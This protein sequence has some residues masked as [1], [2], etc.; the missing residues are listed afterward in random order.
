MWNFKIGRTFGLMFST[1]PFIA[2]R[3]AVYFGCSLILIAG[4]IGGPLLG[5]LLVPE[6]IWVYGFYGGLIF[7]CGV[8]GTIVYFL[9]EY[10]LYLVK[11]GHVAVLVELLEGRQLPKAQLSYAKDIVAE[12]FVEASS[13][14]LIDQV[15]TSVLNVVNRMLVGLG[16]FIPGMDGAMAFIGRV[17]RTS[18]TFADEVILGLSFRTRSTD[19]S[20]SS[21]SFSWHGQA[22]AGLPA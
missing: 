4:M 13:F 15:V 10:F 3:T 14:F 16:S 20:W 18:L 11:A 17:I 2:L 22:P 8:A 21:W 6:T 7:G 1:L 5:V 19:T 9:R 12:R